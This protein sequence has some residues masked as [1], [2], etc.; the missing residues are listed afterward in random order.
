M[1]KATSIRTKAKPQCI[2]CGSDGY[3]LYSHQKD[4]L[5]GVAGDWNIKR[6][7]SVECGLMWLDPSPV[8]EDI[9]LAYQDYYTHT[10]A[11]QSNSSLLS[12]MILA[13]HGSRFGYKSATQARLMRWSGNVLSIIPFFRE[14]MDYPFVYLKDA[15]RGKLLELGVGSGETLKKFIE[16][17]WSAEGLDFDPKAVKA[18]ADIGLNV[19]GGDLEA[20]NFEDESFDAIFSSHVLEHV[21]SPLELMK[22]SLRV[23]KKGGVFVAVTPNANSALHRLFKSNWRG[24]EPP[25]HLNIF[26]MKALIASA[27]MAGFSR[28][29]VVTSN[30]I[31]AGVFYH[32]AALAGVRRTFFLRLFSNFVRLLLTLFHLIFKGS[33]EELILVAYK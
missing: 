25:R 24:L 11:T 13:Y 14:H 1:K 33:G 20:Q 27:K 18:C 7:S 26:T 22:E 16:C 9:H 10:S 29:Q 23:L 5:F 2:S 30:F 31:A 3:S 6:C 21:P 8:P 17:G 4:R 15:K 32:S 28:V 19:R 12:R